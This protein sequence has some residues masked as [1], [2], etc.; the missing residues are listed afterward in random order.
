MTGCMYWNASG[1]PDSMGDRISCAMRF[2]CVSVFYLTYPGAAQRDCF[3]P[4][5]GLLGRGSVFLFA[6]S[7]KPFL[8]F[9]IPAVHADI[10]TL[11]RAANHVRVNIDTDAFEEVHQA[12]TFNHLTATL[13]LE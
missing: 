12:D 3:D 10:G 7:L 11:T 8:G 6:L 1:Q 4:A 2:S 9:F 5:T 13:M